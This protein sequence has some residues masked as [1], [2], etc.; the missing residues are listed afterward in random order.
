MERLSLIDLSLNED[1]RALQTAAAQ[2]F[3]RESPTARVR[4]AEPCGFDEKLWSVVSDAGWP[5]MGVAGDD[6]AADS[7][8]LAVVAQELG[9]ALAPVP[10]IE[11]MV[12]TTVLS[13]SPIGSQLL[14][15]A[16]DGAVPTILLQPLN[17][18]VATGVPAGAVADILVALRGDELI[19]VTRPSNLE[20]D[21]VLNNLGNLPIANWDLSAAHEVTLQSG[22]EAIET[23]HA[24]V[25]DW[26]FLMAAALTGLREKVLEIGVAYVKE[27]HAFGVPIGW[28]QAVQHRFADAV[29]AGDGA[30]L[31]MYEA[32]WARDVQQPT[33]EMLTNMAFLHGADAA[34]QTARTA[35]QFHGGYGFTME[36]DIQ[37][38]FR[39]AKAW[40][41]QGGP[42]ATA[43]RQLSDQLYGPREKC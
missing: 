23:F 5:T 12:A 24:A 43:S 15:S 2:L 38:Y 30:R 20:S 9:R 40:P 32:A 22:P 37:L 21:A 42:L 16:G 36:Y 28:F 39:R 14:K 34:F 25:S 26:R 27:R 17:G 19:A 6:R 18:T 7:V 8:E 29:V 33:A 13:R 35:L 4:D 3:A 10:L 1:Q 11:A 31:L 41:L